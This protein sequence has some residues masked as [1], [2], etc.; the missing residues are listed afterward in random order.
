M[1][2]KIA[3]EIFKV[4]KK[5]FSVIMKQKNQS[6]HFLK[7]KKNYIPT[8]KHIITITFKN[9]SF[10]LQLLKSWQVSNSFF[11]FFYNL[12]SICLL[13]VYSPFISL[14]CVVFFLVNLVLG[15]EYSKNRYTCL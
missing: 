12:Q 3:L 7:L 14:Q 2:S 10:H 8:F 1:K 13:S 5:G 9:K 6:I 15:G 11:F 4:K